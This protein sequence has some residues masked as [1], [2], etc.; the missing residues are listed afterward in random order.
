MTGSNKF[1]SKV[2]S[3]KISTM[4]MENCGATSEQ[5]EEVVGLY[6]RFFRYNFKEIFY[7]T[8]SFWQRMDIL[9]SPNTTHPQFSDIQKRMLEDVR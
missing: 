9:V 4:E 7:K 8:N 3:L 2:H 5:W 6:L 1:G